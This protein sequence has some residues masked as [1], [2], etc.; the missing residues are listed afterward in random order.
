VNLT[1]WKVREFNRVAQFDAW[2]REKHHMAKSKGSDLDPKDWPLQMPE[3]EWDEQ[4][5][6]WVEAG[7]PQAT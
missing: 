5:D 1:H 7:C 6:L 3:A 4:F 2:W